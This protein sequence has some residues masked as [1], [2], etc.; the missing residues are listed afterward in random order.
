MSVKHIHLLCLSIKP[1]FVK[2]TSKPPD[3]IKSLISKIKLQCLCTCLS[4]Y[5]ICKPTIKQ[6]YMLMTQNA[7]S[8]HCFQFI[9]VLKT[10]KIIS[11]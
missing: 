10:H 1:F 5:F 2:R 4:I 3:I 6:N 11:E 9:A 8:V 7:C